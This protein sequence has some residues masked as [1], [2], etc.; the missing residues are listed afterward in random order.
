MEWRSD[1]NA[2]EPE[3]WMPQVNVPRNELGLL[4]ARPSTPQCRHPV[5]LHTRAVRFPTATSNIFSLTA[6]RPDPIVPRW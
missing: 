3:A 1:L 4:G 5:P 2:S 6:T